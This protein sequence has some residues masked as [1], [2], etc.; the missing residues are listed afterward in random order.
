M[1]A[2]LLV[3]ADPLSDFPDAAA[4]RAALE[5]AELVVAVDGFL[6]ASAALAHVVLPAALAHERGGTTTNIEGRV[7]RLGQKLVPPGQCW[8]DWMIAAELAL[9]L[10]GDL[11]VDSSAALWDEI[12]RLAPSHAGIT[13]AALD[14]P[15]AR[16]G[17][18][19]PLRAAPVS[20]RRHGPEPFDPMATPGIE[21]VEVQGAPPRTGLAEPSGGEAEPRAPGGGGRPSPLRWP[22]P[23]P[24][25]SLPAPDRYSLRLVA[26]RRLYDDGVFL[27]ACPSLSPLADAAEARAHPLELEKLG[28][29][30]GGPV[31]VRS[32]RGA[33]VLPAVPDAA[34]ARGVVSVD[35]NL[36]V[37]GTPAAAALID[38]RQAVVDVRLETP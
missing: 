19:A 14:A 4:A 15:A 9:R 7:T 3:G 16:D 26:G 29:G 21:S 8:P 17:I 12:E 28:L 31:R 37:H 5:R 1:A 33:V 10:D 36:A 25:P 20:L 30:S 32:P 2:V 35:F 23:V 22:Q 11:A 34:M 38:A 6:S 27:S 18:V 13:R 24:A